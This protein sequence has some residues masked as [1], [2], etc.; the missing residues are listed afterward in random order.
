MFKIRPCLITRAATPLTHND[1][2]RHK[3]EKDISLSFLFTT[4]AQQKFLFTT[5]IKI[6]D[7][8]H[9][10]LYNTNRNKCSTIPQGPRGKYLTCKNWSLIFRQQYQESTPP[11]LSLLGYEPVLIA[12]ITQIADVHPSL[13]LSTLVKS[14]IL[15][16]NFYSQTIKP[17][18]LISS[19]ETTP[20][21]GNCN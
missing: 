16:Y 14:S 8:I 20:L 5:E 17:L 2:L 10:W 7:D 6:S 18:L 19:N 21:K 1:V 12:E 11:F 13:F 4:G 15:K 9:T 3:V